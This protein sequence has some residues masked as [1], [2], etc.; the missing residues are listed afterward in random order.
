MGLIFT[1]ASYFRTAFKLKK[2]QF[3]YT[4]N[5][6]MDGVIAYIEEQGKRNEGKSI[7]DN[8]TRQWEGSKMVHDVPLGLGNP[9]KNDIQISI[10]YGASPME[11]GAA[12]DN[13]REFFGQNSNLQSSIQRSRQEL[14]KQLGKDYDLVVTIPAEPEKN[15]EERLKSIDLKTSSPI[16]CWIKEARISFEFASKENGQFILTSDNF[17]NQHSG[18][19]LYPEIVFRKF[20]K[21][22]N[23][24]PDLSRSNS[25][26][27]VVCLS[28]AAEPDHHNVTGAVFRILYCSDHTPKEIVGYKERFHQQYDS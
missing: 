20:K 5:K 24:I 17:F 21:P 8:R 4:V 1:Q 2:T 10:G 19:Q 15:L 18:L 26:F 27:T 14:Q 16:A 23:A 11:Y 12:V 7:S 28:F 6:V 3:D 13:M 25:R 9:M 22:G